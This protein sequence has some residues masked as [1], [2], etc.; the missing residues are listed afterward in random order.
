MLEIILISVAW[1]KGWRWRALLPSAIAWPLVFVVAASGGEDAM[2]AVVLI[3]LA[4]IVALITMAVKAPAP[5]A[6]AGL[7]PG[8]LDLHYSDNRLRTEAEEPETVG[9]GR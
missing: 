9:A 5:E 2:G 3:A 4:E 1:R 7:R 8:A 6:E